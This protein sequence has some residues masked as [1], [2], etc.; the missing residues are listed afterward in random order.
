VAALIAGCGGDDAGDTAQAGR[1]VTETVTDTGPNLA[2]PANSRQPPP[3]NSPRQ[4][5]AA[6]RPRI[7]QRRI[8]FP[9]KRKREMAAYAQRHYGIASSSLTKPRVI[10]EHVT[11]TPD[12]ESVYN[13]FANDTADPELGELPGVCSHFVVDRDGTIYQLVPLDI[14]CRHTV[15]LNY[16][17]IGIEHVGQTDADVL[18]NE[19]QLSA[20]LAL[21]RWLRCRYDIRPRD[22][23]G[24]NESLSS[25]Y[26]RENVER[27][28]TQTHG[29]MARASMKDYRRSLGAPGC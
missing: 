9:Q 28:R 22:V 14:M 24:H 23:I 16:T 26:H 1:T 15:G 6:S 8:P 7:V 10:V 2:P 27:L 20:S 17:S 4:P 29:D 21:T 18:G 12:F 5:P 11:V 25:R 3:A 19:R 13:T